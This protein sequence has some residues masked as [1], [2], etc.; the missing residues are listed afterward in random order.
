[1]TIPSCA[2]SGLC[3]A[4]APRHPRRLP[5][6]FHRL[7]CVHFFSSNPT[8]NTP[9]LAPPQVACGVEGPPPLPGQVAQSLPS[10]PDQRLVVYGTRGGWCQEIKCEK[11][12]PG[13]RDR[14]VDT[15]WVAE[16]GVLPS[17]IGACFCLPGPEGS[18]TPSSNPGTQWMCVL[19]CFCFLNNNIYNMISGSFVFPICNWDPW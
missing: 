3:E 7:V 10:A 1:M 17:S 6:A 2:A 14:L 5:D 4:V 13:K 15:T 11:G 12:P 19:F 9:L 18:T 16:G 8:P